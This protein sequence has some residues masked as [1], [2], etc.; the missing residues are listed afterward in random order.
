MST[1]RIFMSVGALCGFVGYVATR[2]TEDAW[3]RGLFIGGTVFAAVMFLIVPKGRSAAVDPGG[4]VIATIPENIGPMERG[5]K[6][7]DPLDELLEEHG[8]GEISGGGSS[9]DTEAGEIE[10][11]DIEIDL[12]DLDKGIPLVRETLRR[13]GAPPGSTL[14]FDR[15]GVSIELLIRK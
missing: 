2:M 8:I 14:S 1:S 13:L 5:A 9:I 12:T 7:E 3:A 10:Y 6:Y 11:V 4:Y 15:H